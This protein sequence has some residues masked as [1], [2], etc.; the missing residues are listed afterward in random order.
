MERRP[1]EPDSKAGLAA[2]IGF[3]FGLA[4][5]LAS[6]FWG[7]NFLPVIFA[8]PAVI[9]CLALPLAMAWLFYWAAIRL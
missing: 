2:A 7:L 4:L 6:M 1:V 5:A 8:V 3:S 9:G